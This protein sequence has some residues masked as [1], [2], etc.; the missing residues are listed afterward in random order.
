MY[1]IGRC[2]C[3]GQC[4]TRVGKIDLLYYVN[5]D[6]WKA[7]IC[8]ITVDDKVKLPISFVKGV[9]EYDFTF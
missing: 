3:A 5:I 9:V 8:A 4:G 1:E 7:I 6:S 2:D